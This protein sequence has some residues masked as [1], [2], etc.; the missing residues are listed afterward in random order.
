MHRI[1]KSV[2]TG[3]QEKS[4][5]KTATGA[6]LIFRRPESKVL[7]DVSLFYKEELKQLAEQLGLDEA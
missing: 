6:P 1:C 7:Y 4:P 3:L 2:L 5:K